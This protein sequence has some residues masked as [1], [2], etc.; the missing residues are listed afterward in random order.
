VQGDAPLRFGIAGLGSGASNLLGGFA[1]NPHVRVTAAADVRREALDAFAREFGAEA[2]G[3]VEDMCR[4]PHVDAVWVATPNHLHAEHVITAAEHGKHV[5]VSKPMALTLAECEE[6][7]A[8]AERCGVRLLAGH[9]QGL[10]APVRALAALVRGGEYGR[11]GMVHTWHYS[12]WIYRPR[13]P[14]E[15]DESQG[16]GVVFRQAPHQ[17]DIVRLI[18]GGLVRSVRAMTMQLDARRPGP[19]AY[20]AYLE[21]AD[22]RPAT[23]VYSG[24]GHFPISELTFGRGYA[25][26]SLARGAASAEEEAAL[27]ETLR[28]TGRPRA[29]APPDRSAGDE[30]APFG[31]TL[32]TCERADLRQSPGGLYVYDEQGRREVPVPRDELRGEAELE[33]LYQAVVHDRPILHDGRWGQATLEVT[34]GILESAR[35]GKEVFMR[36]QTAVPA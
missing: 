12:N 19:G 23:L 17:I 31:L 6:M 7:N 3:S 8:A 25:P 14:Y 18:G 35:E 22:R 13:M 36:H 20:V 11:L 10:A 34:L 28:Y 30:H 24:Y 16:G 15:L 26:P 9:S 4:S 27:K 2:Y 21:F 32:V 29:A 5:V 1:Q 33:E